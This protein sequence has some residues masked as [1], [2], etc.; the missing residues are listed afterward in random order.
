MVLDKEFH[1]KISSLMD[2]CLIPHG[3]QTQ[4]F[5]KEFWKYLRDE[6]FKYGQKA[7]FVLGITLGYYIAKYGKSPSDEDLTEISKMVESRKDEI[8]KSFSDIHFSHK[9]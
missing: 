3:I 4:E 1:A 5:E 6:D 2:E 7:G 8:R 9:V